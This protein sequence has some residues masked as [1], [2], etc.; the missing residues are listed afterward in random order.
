MSAVR[1]REVHG[2][3]KQRLWVIADAA[4]P[5]HAEYRAK[6][7]RDI[8]ILLLE[9]VGSSGTDPESSGDAL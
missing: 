6:A 2:G 1:A 5:V 3:E 8:P 9:R 4:N 7:G